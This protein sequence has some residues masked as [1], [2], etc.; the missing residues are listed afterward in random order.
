VTTRFE[1]AAWL[2]LAY[3]TGVILLGAWVRISGSGAGCGNHWP[4]CNGEV[5]PVAPGIKTLTEFSHRLT[6]GLC[7]VIGIVMLLWARRVNAWVLRAAAASF[8]FVLV[9]GFVGAV[10]VKKELVAGDTSLS[11][12]I[13]I[14]L[15]LVNTLALTASTAAMAWWSRPRAAASTGASRVL[16][17]AAIVAIV[18]SCMTGAITALGD[19]LFPR[20]PALTGDL[21]AEV[22][23]DVS[24]GQHFLVR[25]RVLHPMIAVV[26]AMITALALFGMRGGS[27]WVLAGRLA[28]GLQVALG[29]LNIGLAAPGWMQ[30][31]HL[32]NAQILWVLLVVH[33][34][35][36]R[37]AARAP[38]V[39][40]T[41][42]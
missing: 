33:A 12:A 4:L 9:E 10:L 40:A 23:A 19:T 30:I 14:A 28:L 41:G 2:Y 22:R 21:L 32:L 3:L 24:A 8:F 5:V 20:Q 1:R 34:F 38:I 13:V 18:V 26:S 29:F 27:R 42:R 37:A 31:V 16:L 17:M 39:M 25:L 15:H 7:G 6:S 35:P 11:R 36:L